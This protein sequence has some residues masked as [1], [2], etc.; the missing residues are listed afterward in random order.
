MVEAFFLCLDYNHVPPLVVQ[1][2]VAHLWMK[3][4]QYIQSASVKI[5]IIKWMFSFFSYLRKRSC[6]YDLIFPR[7][8]RSEQPWSLW[9]YNVLLGSADYQNAAV[10]GIAKNSSWNCWQL[11]S[12][13]TLG[14]SGIWI[15]VEGLTH[16]HSPRWPWVD[17]LHWRE[18]RNKTQTR[19]VGKHW[20]KRE[21]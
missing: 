1:S 3:L 5:I 14:V 17:M 18:K 4:Y 6:N 20:K 21:G 11:G 9:H 15:P 19:R 8:D 7:F 13:L 16:Q 12:P 10:V 2:S